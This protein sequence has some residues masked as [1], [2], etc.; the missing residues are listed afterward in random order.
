[1]KDIEFTNLKLSDIDKEI[2]EKDKIKY[3]KKK[4]KSYLKQEGPLKKVDV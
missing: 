2:I 3:K 1:M 4:I